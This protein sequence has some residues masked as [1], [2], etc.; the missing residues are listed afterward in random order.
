MATLSLDETH[1]GS[2]ATA[3]KPKP[4]RLSR[5]RRPLVWIASLGSRWRRA[6][7]LNRWGAFLPQVPTTERASASPRW[8]VLR[9][10]RPSR[11]LRHRARFR[12]T[13][14]RRTP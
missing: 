1:C 3:S 12:E 11:C 13:P 5:S 10:R 9:R 4:S 14:D 7:K 8:P 6:L 2:S